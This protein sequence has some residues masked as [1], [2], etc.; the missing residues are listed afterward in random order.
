[1]LQDRAAGRPIPAAGWPILN[2]AFFA[3]FRVGMLKAYPASEVGVPVQSS[4][5]RHG[6]PHSSRF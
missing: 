2:F 3:K 1:M 6:L 4:L 5:T